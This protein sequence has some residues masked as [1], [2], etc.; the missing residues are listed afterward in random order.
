MFTGVT[1]TL[2]KLKD[3]N[4]NLS[5]VSSSDSK[6]I[7]AYLQNKCITYLFDLIIGYDGDV[8]NLKPNPEGIYKVFDLHDNNNL[9]N[10]LF[11]KDSLK[12]LLAAK[13]ANIDFCLFSSKANSVVNDSNELLKI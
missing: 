8:S 1:Y 4:I 12:D 11:V 10:Y 6:N 5:T 3:K 7:K 9:S 13:N 2:K